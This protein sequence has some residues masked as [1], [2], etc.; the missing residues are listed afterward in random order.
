MWREIAIGLQSGNE[1]LLAIFFISF[2]AL[3]II[4]E[5]ILMLSFVFNINFRKFLNAFRKLVSSRSYH[6]AANLCRATSNTSLPLIANRAL[7]ALDNDP[8]TIKSVI[9]EETIAL[10]PRI[11][12]RI[13]FLP[14]SATLVLL[15]G[16]LGTI[17]QIWSAFYSINVLDTAQKQVTLANGIAKSLNPTALGLLVSMIILAM[18]Q[19][20]KSSALRVME[21]IHHGVTVVSNLIAPPDVMVGTKVPAV[22]KA[23]PSVAATALA[24]DKKD[25]NEKGGKKW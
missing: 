16:V 15:L 2:I 25:T 12:A 10:L 14:M 7:D 24:K 22:K 23:T 21:N 9:E 6:Q 13:A 20:I 18:H 5:R 11:E 1:Y 17:D 3:L 19:F 4:F 8:S